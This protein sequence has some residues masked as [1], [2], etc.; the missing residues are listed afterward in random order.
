VDVADNLKPRAGAGGL[1]ALSAVVVCGPGI[2]LIEAERV[3]ARSP[4]LVRV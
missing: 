4:W 1:E 2:G 3:G